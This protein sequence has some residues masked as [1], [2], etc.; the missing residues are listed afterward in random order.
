MKLSSALAW[1][2]E[3]QTLL[4]RGETVVMVT[5]AHTEGDAPCRAGAKLLVARERLS[6]SLGG[7]AFESLAVETARQLLKQPGRGTARSLQRT[8]VE[9]AGPGTHV[10]LAFERLTVADLAWVSQLA[11]RLTSGQATVRSVG[12]G[13]S[14][15]SVLLSDTQ[16]RRADC[17]LWAAGPL[18]SETLLDDAQAL[19]LCG[20]GAFAAALMEMLAKLPF[21]IDWYDAADTG[22]PGTPSGSVQRVVGREPADIVAAMPS[23]AF[24]VIATDSEALDLSLVD[25]V[26]RRGDAAFFGLRGS[27][28]KR[29]RFERQ[30]ASAGIEPARLAALRQPLGIPGIFQGSPAESALAVAAHLMRERESLRSATR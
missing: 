7:G 19:L 26:V 9:E 11:K 5:A 20:A 12:F 24:Y 29:H 23:G 3:L 25:A 2:G 1:L 27:S 15:E 16:A 28:W 17:L 22:M 10:A 21:R 14:E 6:G 4:T 8:S 18:L 13:Q 30:L